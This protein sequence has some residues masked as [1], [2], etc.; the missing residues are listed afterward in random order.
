MSLGSN[1]D[2][3]LRVPASLCGVFS[4]KSSYGRLSR[5][6]SF[7]FVD[8]LDHLGPLARSVTDLALVYDAMQGLARTT[9]AA[10]TARSSRR[11][12]VPSAGWRGAPLCRGRGLAARSGGAEAGRAAACLITNSESAA[13]HLERLHHRAEEFDPDT[14]DRFLAV[15]HVAKCASRRRTQHSFRL[16]NVSRWQSGARS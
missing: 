7:S 9:T 14:N 4:L 1:T 13:F 11:V 12:P 5:A 3:S 10:P 15:A 6:G 2:G 16:V 8:S